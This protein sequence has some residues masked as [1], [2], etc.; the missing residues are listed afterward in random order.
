MILTNDLVQKD[1][2]AI[3]K[4]FFASIMIRTV[5]G[6]LRSLGLMAE[7]EGVKHYP[8][9]KRSSWGWLKQIW[10]TQ[11]YGVWVQCIQASCRSLQL[12][13]YKAIP[14]LI[15]ERSLWLGASKWAGE[16]KKSNIRSIFKKDKKEDLEIY[17]KV[18]LVVVSGKIM[19]QILLEAVF[20]HMMGKNI[21]G[22]YQEQ[23]NC[24]LWWVA[25]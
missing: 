15:F 13:L 19:K 11:I 5:F 16:K 17:R 25:Q 8:Q 7:L 20:R 22:I 4:A 9:Y 1:L 23:I 6:L 14:L 12:S 3:L 10:C 21:I 24:P 18:S 2:E